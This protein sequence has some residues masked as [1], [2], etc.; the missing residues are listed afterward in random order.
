MNNFI[1]N[2][3]RQEIIDGEHEDAG[4]NSMLIQIV[5]FFDTFPMPKK[6]FKVIYQFKFD[7]VEQGLTVIS[8]EQVQS[9]AQ[10]LLHA[11]DQGMN[12]VVHCFA[13]LC[14]SGAVVDVGVELGFNPPD[15]QGF[16]NSTVRQKLRKELGLAIDAD[17]S[18]FKPELESWMYD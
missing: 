13:G 7:D 2:I 1:T 3:S 5:D 16:P 14:R 4:V 12:V 10:A 6:D 11:K 9:I 15:R 18:T 17:T 8:N